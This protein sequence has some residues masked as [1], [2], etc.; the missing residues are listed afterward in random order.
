MR[1][2]QTN[3]NPER[4]TVSEL[5][6]ALEVSRSGY[7]AAKQRRPGKRESENQILV[8]KMK[9]I[10]AHRHTRCYGSPRM[11]RELL[12]AGLP[13]SENRVARL[14]NRHGI[15]ASL[16]A[17]FRPQT[18]L[19]DKDQL[20]LPNLLKHAEPPTDPGCVYV[21]DITYVATRE[22]WLYLA[23]VMDL[24]S[25][26][27]VGW[28]LD[29]HMKTSLVTEALEIAICSCPPRKEALFHSDQ[30]CQYTSEKMQCRLRELRITQSM[31]RKGNCYDNAKSESFFATLKRE[32]FPET[33]CF[34]TK[35]EA[36][37]SIFD[38]LETFY[39]RKRRHSSLGNLSP[40]AFLERHFQTQKYKLN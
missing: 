6:E 25:R 8:E 19:R 23:I 24:Y 27:I 10:H 30:G 29:E 22:G 38:Y 39:N 40:S 5:C 13:C 16:R 36:R 17:A 4:Y 20:P 31:S 11:T 1:E 33:C 12:E 35:A 26:Q 37:R 21:S 34:E 7:Y 9:V 2:E 18:T 3:L 28:A 14:M 15:N 32:A